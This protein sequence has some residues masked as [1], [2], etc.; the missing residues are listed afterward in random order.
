MYKFALA[1]AIGFFITLWSSFPA[2]AHVLKIDGSIGAVLHI[3]PDDA[4]RVNEPTKYEVAFHDENGKFNLQ[5]CNCS[6]VIQR[7]NMTVLAAALVPSE[8]E[9]SRNRVTFMETGVYSM[10]F[11]GTPKTGD[12]FQPF[13]L[14]YEIRVTNGQAKLRSIPVALWIGMAMAVALILLSSFA[15]DYTS[16]KEESK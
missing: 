16:M 13:T 8:R 3:E 7:N 12:T 5:A 15:I 14:N 6:V 4:P 11:I 1:L 9:L 10:R 2:D